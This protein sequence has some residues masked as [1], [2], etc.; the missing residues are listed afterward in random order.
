MNKKQIAAKIY[1]TTVLKGIKQKLT[2]EQYIEG[3]SRVFSK[4]D[5]LALLQMALER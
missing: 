4:N 5:L 1:D 2:R 3:Y